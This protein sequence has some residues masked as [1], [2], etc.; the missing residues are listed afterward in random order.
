M[1][2]REPS[3]GVSGPE[4]GRHFKFQ[5]IKWNDNKS[6]AV[7]KNLK[8]LSTCNCCLCVY[9]ILSVSPRDVFTGEPS[10]CVALMEPL[11]EVF[12]MLHV[13]N[14]QKVHPVASS[15]M[16]KTCRRWLLIIDGGWTPWVSDDDR[17]KRILVFMQRLFYTP[18][19]RTYLTV[20]V[21]QF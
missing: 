21:M 16:R 5:W 11:R 14:V 12:G 10:G 18:L 9:Q 6:V 3:F 7:K 8:D 20:N 4:S 17:T 13:E 2:S 15:V 19:L 1:A